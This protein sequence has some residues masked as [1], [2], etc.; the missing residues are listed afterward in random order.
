MAEQGKRYL[1]PIC[2]QEVTVVKAGAGLLVCCGREME[3]KE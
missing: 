3:L 2:G 1:C